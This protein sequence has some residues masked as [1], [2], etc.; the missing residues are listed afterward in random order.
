M[1]IQS[2]VNISRESAIERILK[3][4]GLILDKDYLGL[5]SNS[6][7]TEFSIPSFI[8]NYPPVYINLVGKIDKES[9]QKWTDKMLEGVMDLPF[10]RLSMFDN[11]RISEDE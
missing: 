3:I 7:E 2:T 9:L 8:D 10:Y 1:G 4:Q 5:Q 11:Y 6:F